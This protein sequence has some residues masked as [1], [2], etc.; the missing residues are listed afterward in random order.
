MKTVRIL[1]VA[2]ALALGSRE[3]GAQAP[4][5]SDYR[6]IGG[7]TNHVWKSEGWYQMSGKV[8]Q[9]KGGVALVSGDVWMW[10]DNKQRGFW[11]VNFVVKNLPWNLIDD[12][13]LPQGVFAKYVGDIEYTTVLGAKKTVRSFDYGKPVEGPPEP[14]VLPPMVIKSKERLAQ[15]AKVEANRLKFTLSQATNGVASAQYELG[16]RYLEGRGVEKDELAARS[17]LEKAAGKGHTYAKR[18]LANLP[19]ESK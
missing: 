17:W 4:P 9:G 3:A 18:A 7:V 5:K 1:T 12:D 13:K 14:P 19:G 16:L 15:E 2:A 8:L 6:E 11:D 10:E